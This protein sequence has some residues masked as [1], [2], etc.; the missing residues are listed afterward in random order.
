M[1][2][3]TS[4]TVLA[5]VLETHVLMPLDFADHI[6]YSHAT[7]EQKETTITTLHI[8]IKPARGCENSV[9]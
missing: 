5:K 8:V 6:H 3:T 2:S 1:L 7:Y 4:A 9:G